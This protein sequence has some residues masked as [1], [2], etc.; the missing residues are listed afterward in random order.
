M[1][2][3]TVYVY[4]KCSTCRK[5]LKWLDDHGLTYEERSIREQPPTLPELQKA[6]TTVGQLRPLLNTSSQDYRD[7]GLKDTLDAMAPE[8]VFKRLMANGN[9]IKRPFVVTPNAA[10][11]GF[12][13]ETWAQRLL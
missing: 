8:A 4:R 12:K 13:E 1:P 5:A 6:L 11:A 2:E 7:S 10:F 9:L 3:L